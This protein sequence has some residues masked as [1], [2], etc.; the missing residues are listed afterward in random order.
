MPKEIVFGIDARKEMFSGIKVLYESV[1]A[2]LGPR[3]RNVVFEKGANAPSIT[4]DGVTVAKEVELEERLKN[5]GLKIVLEAALE[6]A[7][8][9]GD[10]TTTATVLAYNILHE[11]LKLVE[12]GHD[13]IVLKQGIDS[14]VR[15]AVELIAKMSKP[16]STKEEITQVATISANSDKEIGGILSGVL[17]LVGNDGVISIESARSIQTTAEV[18]EGLQFNRGYVS[19]YLSDYDEKKGFVSELVNPFILLYGGRMVA[20][21]PFFP[22]LTAVLKTGRPLL[23]IA[24]DVVGEALSALVVNKSRKV[25]N[26]CAVKSPYLAK[27]KTETM[28]DISVLTGATYI[29]GDLGLNAEALTLAH[30]GS[31][32]KVVVTR[33][34]TTIIGGLGDKTKLTNRIAQVREA[35]DSATG[36]EKER[37]EHRLGRLIGGVTVLHIGAATEVEIKEK[38]DRVDDALKAVRAAMAEGILPGGGVAYLRTA[39]EL[40]K[41]KPNGIDG[42]SLFWGFMIVAKALESPIKAIALNAGVE[43]SVVVNEIK[44]GKGAYGYNAARAEYGDMFDFGIIDPTKVSRVALQSAASVAGLLLTTGAVICNKE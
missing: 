10:G 39:S 32:K 6:T 1:K 9:A 40:I 24:E 33:G 28:E 44:K 35:R 14:A 3:G 7:N 37:L 41:K 8:A 2:T 12:A 4:K 17:E 30:L 20:A 5:T 25:M 38:K 21:K 22:I 36:Q 23:I 43:P 15:V 16:V 26:V 27:A 13:P 19:S 29:T 11:G 31:A 18:V 42:D 34:D